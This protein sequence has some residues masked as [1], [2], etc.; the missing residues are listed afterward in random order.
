MEIRAGQID[1][2]AGSGRH[3]MQCRFLYVAASLKWNKSE[4][5]SGFDAVNERVQSARFV[6][7]HER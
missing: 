1:S 6:F 4:P 7:F 2:R 3:N 5:F